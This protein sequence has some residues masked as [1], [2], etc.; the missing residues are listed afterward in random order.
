MRSFLLNKLVRDKILGEMQAMGQQVTFKK[1][2]DAEYLRELS[3]K[4][5]EEASEFKPDDP[6][7]T[8]KEL[9]DVLEVVEALAA[10]FGADFDQLR[11]VQASRKV[12]RGGFKDRTYISRLDLADDDPWAKYYAKEPDRFK[13]VT[14]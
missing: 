2:N 11:A 1:L 9:A 12:K 8:L 5:V 6:E 10:E 7:D 4:L 3:R 13:E 14:E